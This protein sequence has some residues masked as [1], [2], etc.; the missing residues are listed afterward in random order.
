MLSV[1]QT[2]DVPRAD[3]IRRPRIGILTFLDSRRPGPNWSTTAYFMAQALERHCGEVVHLG[4]VNS[5]VQLLGKVANGVARHLIRRPC[6]FNS[7]WIQARD[8]ARLF[9]PRL[10]GL[11]V[12]LAPSAVPVVALLETSIPIVH[13]SDATFDLVRDYYPFYSGLPAWNVRVAQEMER[14]VLERAA[15][16]VYPSEWAAA[17][18]RDHYNTSPEKI[19]V[20]PYGAC[21]DRVPSHTVATAPRPTDICRLL[22]VATEW[23]RKGGGIAHEAM[24]E[25]RRSGINAELVVVGCEPPRG[26]DRGHLRV[27]RHLDKENHAE[28]EQLSRLYLAAHFL[29]LPTR[30]ECTARVLSEASAHGTPSIATDTG[31]VAGAISSG[32]NGY[33][34]PM[35]ADA[36]AY[37]ALIAA[38][39]RDPT[40]HRALVTS[41]RRLYETRLNWDF[42]GR[43]MAEHLGSLVPP[44]GRGSLPAPWLPAP[45]DTAEHWS[46]A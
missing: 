13:A 12:L 39:F 11:D 25:L 26:V 15:L 7:S 10:D 29:L 18:A 2:R 43:R 24:R 4:P 35:T 38:V 45:L 14:R 33:L 37:A 28:Q 8:W 23:D 22:F 41:S 9:H 46:E 34:L 3:H 30:A 19:H 42:W 31:G 44:I 20:V 32:Q 36:G 27:F 21:F 16:V 1:A 17:S 5:P 6:D 40:R